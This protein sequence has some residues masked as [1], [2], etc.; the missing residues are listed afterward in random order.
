MVLECGRTAVAIPPEA[1]LLRVFDPG[2]D[3]AAFS[4]VWR[5]AP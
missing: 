5:E 4:Q 3:G 1:I 2:F